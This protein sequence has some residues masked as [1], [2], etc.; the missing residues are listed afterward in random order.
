MRKAPWFL[1]GIAILA[2]IAW[3]L[4]S[5]EVRVVNTLVV[6]AL[7]AAASVSHAWLSYGLSWALRYTLIALVFGLGIEAIGVHTG[8]PFSEYVYTEILQP[9]IAG[10]PLVVPL[11]WMMMA[12]PAMIV[13]RVLTSRY[14]TSVLVGAYALSSWDVFLDPQMV[15]E[16]YW[17]WANTDLT[18]PGIPDIPLANFGGWLLSTAV[19]MV[20]LQ[21]LPHQPL[22]RARIGVPTLLYSWTW[23]GGVIANAFFFSR[24]AVA[25]VGG[26][27]MAVVAVPFC[28]RLWQHRH[29]PT[30]IPVQPSASV[31]A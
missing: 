19:L 21:S 10:V 6:V 1:A 12:Y 14:W 29:D 9:Q 16:G 26:L 30:M 7:F 27:A 24:P 8:F 17:V 3:P 4:T 20:I 15:G 18:L 22:T 13:A 31:S 2:Q 28:F 25:L 5:G 23:I 11:A